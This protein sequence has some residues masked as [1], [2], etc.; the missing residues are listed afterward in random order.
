MS[1]DCFDIEVSDDE[2]RRWNTL[3]ASGRAFQRG[4]VSETQ[5]YEWLWETARAWGQRGEHCGGNPFDIE[6]PEYG[7]WQRGF[8]YGCDEADT[9]LVSRGLPAWRSLYKKE[10]VA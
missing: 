1:L 9:H 3:A 10:E 5:Y 4:R 6:E 2:V 8:F 7:I